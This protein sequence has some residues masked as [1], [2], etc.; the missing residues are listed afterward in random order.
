MSLVSYFFCLWQV[1]RCFRR[2]N[3]SIVRAVAALENANEE[4]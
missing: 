1:P 3:I 2:D 4:E